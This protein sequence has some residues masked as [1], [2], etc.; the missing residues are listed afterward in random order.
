MEQYIISLSFLVRASLEVICN[1]SVWSW[2]SH[3]AWNSILSLW[4]A[5]KKSHSI[6]EWEKRLSNTVKYSKYIWKRKIIRHSVNPLFK[7]KNIFRRSLLHYL[8]GS[9]KCSSENISKSISWLKTKVFSYYVHK[10][11]TPKGLH[12]LLIITFSHTFFKKLHLIAFAATCQGYW[13]KFEKVF[14]TENV[15]NHWHKSVSWYAVEIST[16]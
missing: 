13:C 16:F 11:C 6:L 15:K 9:L 10:W 2:H 4:L 5:A 12:L 1:S 8:W 3:I 7:I 14:F